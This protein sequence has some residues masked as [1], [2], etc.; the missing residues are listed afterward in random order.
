MALYI[1]EKL[2]GD[3]MLLDM[4]GQITLGEETATLRDHVK[5]VLERGYRRLVLN[6]WEVDYMDSVG[7]STLVECYAM[8]RAHGAE[9]KL[10][11]LNRRISDLV[12]VTHLITV[13]EIHD[14]L[15]RALN[16]FGGTPA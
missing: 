7:V 1:V 15:E 9:I 2:I 13:F 6:L 14:T 5:Q 10:L 8:A 16:S 3:V 4:R 12:R 11:R